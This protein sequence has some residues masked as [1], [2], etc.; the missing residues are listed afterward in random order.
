M[1]GDKMSRPYVFCRQTECASQ[2]VIVLAPRRNVA[3]KQLLERGAGPRT[4]MNA[5][6]N[7]LD[8]HFREHLPRSFAM[9][10][11]YAIHIGAQAQRKLR[12]VERGAAS[13]GFLNA[14]VIL[15]R[16]KNAL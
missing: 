11:R 9:L 5:I 10:L 16:L 6:C 13:R 12:H 14:R 8:R 4:R 1:L 2:A 15:L 7:R 3:V